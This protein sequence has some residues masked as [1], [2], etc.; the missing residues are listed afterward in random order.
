MII[1]INKTNVNFNPS[2]DLSKYTS[3]QL[4]YC[5]LYNSWYNITEENNILRYRV[6]NSQWKIKSLK[7]GNYNIDT[8][9]EVI[10]LPEK[11]A[12]RKIKPTGKTYLDLAKDWKI[13]FTYQKNFASL[14]GFNNILVEKSRE[15]HNKANFINVEEYIVHCD[16][17]D[18]ANNYVS[19]GG[20][21]NTAV[22]NN[23]LQILPLKDTKE[24]CEKVIYDI[25][26][27]TP[28]PLKR[29]SNLSSINIWITDQLGRPVDFNNYPYI[30]CL[31]LV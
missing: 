2:I 15:S 16:A 30:F 9:T 7:P 3:I 12:F 21:S 23:Y 26:N 25:S 11:I 31:E 29:M 8:L 17:I 5:T 13:D 27:P 4:R 14:V 18:R 22:P 19:I 6:S 10:G 20:S 24:I 28:M 1:W